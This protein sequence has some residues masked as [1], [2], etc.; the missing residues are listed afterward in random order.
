VNLRIRVKI[1]DSLNIND[2]QFVAG[3]LKGEVTESLR[4]LSAE[5]S[6]DESRVGVVLDVIA[7][8][9]VLDVKERAVFALVELVDAHHEDVDLLGRV[10]TVEL[11]APQLGI[12]LLNNIFFVKS[13]IM[14][15]PIS[16]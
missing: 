16:F 1:S 2:D 12:H 8:D 11:L 6:V 5:L 3:P 4:R 15:I 13:I 10:V 7:V 14:T 9:E